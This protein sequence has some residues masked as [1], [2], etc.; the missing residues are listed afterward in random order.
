MSRSPTALITGSNGFVGRWLSEY[1]ISYNYA[2]TGI[3]LQSEAVDKTLSYHQLD[4]SSV[5]E[6]ASLITKLQPDTIFHLAGVTFLP[7]ADKSPRTSLESNISAVLTL[8]ET[9]KEYSPSTR[10]IC[11]G[12][13]KE[14]SDSIFSDGISEK[15]PPQPT[16]F[17]GISKYAGEL[18]ALQYFR[19]FGISV[20]C[21]R[22]FNHT[23][24]RQSPR[25]VCSDWARQVARV[26][27]GL[28]EPFITV[29]DLNATI[30]FTDVRDVV[31]AY[32]LIVEKGQ[33]GEVYN[34]CSGNGIALSW[35]LNYLCDKA[36][37]SIAVQYVESKLRKHRT[38]KKMIGNNRKLTRHTGW[39][40]T[41]PL[42]QTLDEMYDYWVQELKKQQ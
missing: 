34:V 1:L 26:S 4:I 2:V 29:G 11:I 24:P 3:D 9:I 41:I 38:N 17:Y 5:N 22:S 37:C 25:F 8:L 15:V 13:A 39:V 14:Y 27:L 10:L 31:K 30:D 28:A 33:P 40:P 12:S 18:I 23:G 7:Q 42:Q 21:T 20:F 32:H 19:Q 35:I 16:N 36:P 6:A